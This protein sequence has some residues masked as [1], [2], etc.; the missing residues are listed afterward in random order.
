MYAWELGTVASTNT[1]NKSVY[2]MHP[3]PFIM[4]DFTTTVQI[5]LSIINSLERP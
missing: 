5:L 1:G 2:A 4:I 3:L